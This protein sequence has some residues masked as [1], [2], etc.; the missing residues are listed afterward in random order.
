[1]HVGW[2]GHSS[3][4]CS[5]P[6]TW[7]LCTCF[8]HPQGGLRVTVP[9]FQGLGFPQKVLD[10]LLLQ[11]SAAAYIDAFEPSA[12]MHA[13]CIEVKGRDNQKNRTKREYLSEWV[14]AVNSDGRFGQ[15][16]WDVSFRTS[17]IQDIIAKHS[18]N[19]QAQTKFKTNSKR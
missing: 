16:C 11:V 18:G 17:D 5:V 7:V 15:W 8:H 6:S 13:A 14:A 4:P 10:C 12:C 9:F 1:M 2:R 3:Y 19:L